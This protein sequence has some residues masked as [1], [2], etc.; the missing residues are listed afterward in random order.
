MQ[1]VTYFTCVESLFSLR[2]EPR[3]FQFLPLYTGIILWVTVLRF[4]IMVHLWEMKFQVRLKKS[5]IWKTQP[6]SPNPHGYSNYPMF[7]TR[8]TIS[9]TLVY[10]TQPSKSFCQKEISLPFFFL[11]SCCN[12]QIMKNICLKICKVCKLRHV[13]NLAGQKKRFQI[14]AWAPHKEWDFTDGSCTFR[15]LLSIVK[16]QCFY[17]Y[18]VWSPAVPQSYVSV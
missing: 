8:V 10:I 14:Q 3:S 18:K 11:L 6:R 13:D 1:F 4:C 15:Y 17:V 2:G 9:T 7:C 5:V 16:A 12:I